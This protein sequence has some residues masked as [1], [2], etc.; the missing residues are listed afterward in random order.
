MTNIERYSG[1]LERCQGRK[2]GSGNEEVINNKQEQP[3]QAENKEKNPKVVVVKKKVRGREVEVTEID[4]IDVS[5][6]SY[7][8][9]EFQ[10]EKKKIERRSKRF[11]P[12]PTKTLT[13]DMIN[14]MSDQPSVS[15]DNITSDVIDA[16][17]DDSSINDNKTWGKLEQDVKFRKLM[18]YAKEVRDREKLDDTRFKLLKSAL[19]YGLNERKLTKKSDV[20]YDPESGRI[21][22]IANLRYDTEEHVYRL[23]YNLQ[24]TS[25]FG[26]SLLKGKIK[27]K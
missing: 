10:R 27:I 16:E 13:M 14:E 23:D 7:K 15:L 22:E 1:F 19:V 26:K 12:K 4:G 20:D 5:T 6:P 2:N 8:Y 9:A 25:N 3:E 17:E 21:L 18:S 24:L 11:I